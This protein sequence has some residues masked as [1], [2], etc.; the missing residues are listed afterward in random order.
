MEEKQIIER[1]INLFNQAKDIA[2]MDI[3]Y[4]RAVVRGYEARITQLEE[5]LLETDESK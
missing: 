1:K 3:E 5:E 4:K 2:L